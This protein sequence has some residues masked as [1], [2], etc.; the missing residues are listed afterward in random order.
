M[1]VCVY[2]SY[3]WISDVWEASLI[4]G[5]VGMIHQS[6]LFWLTIILVGGTTFAFDVMIEYVRFEYFTNGSDY[7]RAFLREKLGGGWIKNDASFEF[8]KNDFDKI[9]KFMEP[10][11]EA[12]RINDLKRE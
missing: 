9:N 2:V 4:G 7:A 6:P 12:N 1:S 11:K 8:T 3:V 10:I 5:S